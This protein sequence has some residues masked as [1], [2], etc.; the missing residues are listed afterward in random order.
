MC[1]NLCSEISLQPFGAV[2]IER[3]F[4]WIREPE[5]RKTFL[6]DGEV[7][8]T[9]HIKYFNKVIKDAQ[10]KIYAILNDGDHIGNCGLKNIETEESTAELW[11]YI[12]T[13][14]K[15]GKGLGSSVIRLLQHDT[16][17]SKINM[18]DVHVA[19]NNISARR[20][21]SKC[22]FHELGIAAG[23]WA[24]KGSKVLK[25]RWERKRV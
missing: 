9:S 2:H 19:E 5:L 1:K 21:Y 4:L 23:V 8:W 17:S 3:T 20:A 16:L 14:E 18:I 24:N 13:I 6:M 10:Q 15:R 25:M 22:G 12:G 7:S 11:I